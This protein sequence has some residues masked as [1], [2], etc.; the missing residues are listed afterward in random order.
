MCELRICKMLIAI[1]DGLGAGSCCHSLLEQ[2]GDVEIF[3]SWLVGSF[4]VKEKYLII[5][6]FIVGLLLDFHLY[7]ICLLGW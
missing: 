5:Y 4:C 3:L 2:E 1:S 6:L 7:V